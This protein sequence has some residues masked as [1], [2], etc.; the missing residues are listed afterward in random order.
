MID[1]N[2]PIPNNDKKPRGYWLNIVSKMSIGDSYLDTDG[3]ESN[4]NGSKALNA[5]GQIGRKMGMKFTARKVEGGIRIWRV[6]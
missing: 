4:A 5:F 3:K 6:A 1:K 2:I